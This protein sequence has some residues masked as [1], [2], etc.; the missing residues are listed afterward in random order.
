MDKTGQLEI[1]D[2]LLKDV[3]EEVVKITGAINVKTSPISEHE[4]SYLMVI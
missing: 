1:F 3:P 4:V 2:I